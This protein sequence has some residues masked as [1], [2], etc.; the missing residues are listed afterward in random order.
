MKKTTSVLF[1][2]SALLFAASTAPLGS[3]KPAERRHWAFVPRAKPDV[4]KFTAPADRAWAKTPVDSFILASLK[5]NELRPSP[6]ASRAALIRRLYFDLTG[7]PPTPAE[8][9]TFRGGQSRPTP[10]RSWWTGCSPA[11][12][13]ASAGDSTGSTWSDSPRPTASSTT[14]IAR[15][16]AVPRLRDPRLQQRQAVRPLPHRAAGRRRDRARRK[17]RR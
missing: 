4:P 13:T 2:V 11:R 12:I 3:Y 14:R 1:A 17:T 8:V 16:L 6:Q 15:R 7:L 9:A 10:M 5:K